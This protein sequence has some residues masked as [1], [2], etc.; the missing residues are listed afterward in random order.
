MKRGSSLRF[1]EWPMPD[2][3][4]LVLGCDMGPLPLLLLGS[5]LHRLDDVDVAGA[6][7]EVAGDRLAN[8]ELRRVP[9]LLEQRAGRHQ[10]ARR[11]VAALEAVLLPKALLH[12][13]ELAVL[14]EALHRR[15]RAAVGL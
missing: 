7:A 6:A 4:V 1:I 5:V 13:V 15:H 12:G 2:T 8:L 3:S 11:A 10:H 9:V 14:F